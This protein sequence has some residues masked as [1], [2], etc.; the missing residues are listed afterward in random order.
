MY[1]FHFFLCHLVHKLQYDH[2]LQHVFGGRPVRGNQLTACGS[3]RLTRTLL[4][5]AT[6]T[7]SDTSPEQEEE[8]IV[9]IS[10]F[11]AGAW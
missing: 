5:L 10:S 1:M 2:M 9:E 8:A 4:S 6:F 7:A 3:D 11:N